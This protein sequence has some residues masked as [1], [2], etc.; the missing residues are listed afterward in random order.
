MAGEREGKEYWHMTREELANLVP[1]LSMEADNLYRQERYSEAYMEYL[2]AV[3]CLDFMNRGENVRRSWRRQ[4]VVMLL[5][6][7]QCEMRMKYYQMAIAHCDMI[8]E[9]DPEN[10][11]AL[12][13]KALSLITY[14]K[15]DEARTLLLRAGY[16]DAWMDEIVD[17][18]LA[19]I[20]CLEQEPSDATNFAS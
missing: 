13:R 5:D 4:L 11:R 9:I 8:L 16:L 6:T 14:R 17:R 19:R 18:Q 1:E 12:H 2:K 10:V 7:V 20:A 3:D 15:F